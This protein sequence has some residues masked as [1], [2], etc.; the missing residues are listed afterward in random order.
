[1]ENKITIQCWFF[2]YINDVFN[3]YF[4]ECI[5]FILFE[6]C[7]IIKV[8]PISVNTGFVAYDINKYSLLRF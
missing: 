2:L 5:F 1:M 8:F 3:V 7:V 6:L 4:A